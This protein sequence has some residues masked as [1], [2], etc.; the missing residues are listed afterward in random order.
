MKRFVTTLK[1]QPTVVV[2]FNVDY[3]DIL[4]ASQLVNDIKHRSFLKIKQEMHEQIDVLTL[5]DLHFEIK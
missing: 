5:D 4:T 1:K 2:D 3:K